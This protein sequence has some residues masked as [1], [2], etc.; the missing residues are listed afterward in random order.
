MFSTA[1]VRFTGVGAAMSAANIFPVT[2]ADV[3]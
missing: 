1:V 3:A 2:W